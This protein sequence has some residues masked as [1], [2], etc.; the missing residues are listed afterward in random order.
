MPNAK[1]T[2][3][4]YNSFMN[5]PT[6]AEIE[7]HDYEVQSLIEKFKK[8]QVGQR[9]CFI[10]VQLKQRKLIEPALDNIMTAL[11]VMGIDP[12]FPYPLYL[13]TPYVKRFL[14]IPIVTDR[15]NLPKHFFCKTGRLNSKEQSLLKKNKML[16]N[17]ISNHEV[18]D[19]TVH[20][21]TESAARRMLID[22]CQENEFLETIMDGLMKV[23]EKRV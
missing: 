1:I 14:D 2:P 15:K 12:R 16:A 13:I 9:P 23:P 11:E 5:I 22:V 18:S 6:L 21:K 8:H 19:I 4:L 10:E 20:I 3:L 17:K 7:I